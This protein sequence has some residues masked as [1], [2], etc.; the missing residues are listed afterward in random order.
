MSSSSIQYFG[1]TP[2][3][4]LYIGHF[5]PKSLVG[6]FGCLELVLYGIRV[7]HYEQD[8]TNHSKSSLDQLTNENGEHSNYLLIFDVDVSGLLDCS[9]E[10]KITC[11]KFRVGRLPWFKLFKHGQD[12]QDYLQV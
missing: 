8:P 11:N 3:P 12:D 9:G 10:G 4:I 6:G 7:E 1:P 5:V 2:S